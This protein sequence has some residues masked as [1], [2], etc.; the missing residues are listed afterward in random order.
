MKRLSNP[1][2]RL[3]FP[4]WAASTATCLC[5][6]SVPLAQEAVPATNTPKL[7]ET[8]KAETDYRNWFDVSVGGNFIKGDKASFQERH[9][10]PKGA[11]GGVEDFHYEQDLGKK[12]LFEIDGRGIFDNQDYS[13]RLNVQHPDYGYLRG[14]YREFRTW[15]DSSGGYLPITD[16]FFHLKDEEL[17]LDRGELWFE[18]GLT[19]PEMPV[20]T[21]RYSHQF[22]D[23]RKDSTIWGDT[24]LGLT[25]G[26]VRGVVPSFLAI[27][28]ERDIFEFDAEHTI[29]DTRFGVGLRYENSDQNDSRNILRRP[30]EAPERYLTEREIVE[31]DLFNVH[32]FQETWFTETLLFTTGYSFTTMDTDIGGSRIYGSDYDSLY[33][34][35]FVRRQQRDEGFFDLA[36][37]TKLQQHVA[38]LNLMITPFDN[39][40]IVPSLRIENQ[41]QSGIASFEETNVGAP[42]ALTST[43]EEILNTRERGFTDV[44]EGLE[45]RYTGFTNWVLYT[46]G[47]W[48]EGEGNLSERETE[49]ETGLVT[50][51]TDSTRFTQKYVVGANWYP[52]R[53]LNL[54]AQYYHKSRKND[55]DHLTDSTS[56]ALTSG[57]R[58]PAFIRDQDFTTDDVNFRVTIR[59]V[60]QLTFVSRYDFQLST[61]DSRMDNLDRVQSADIISH[62]FGESIS[63][64]P[65]N[66]LFLQGSIN[67]AIDRAETPA[68]GI[69]PGD[70]VQRSDND[71]IDASLTA[72]YAL[73]EKT[74]LQAQYFVYYSDNY[75]DNSAFSV[76]YNAS[77][78]EHGI[79]G[80]L[81]HRFTSAMQWTLKY[82][83]FTLSD[84]TYGGR[85]DYEAHMIYSSFR[86]R[87]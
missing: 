16:R 32:A 81:I 79:T 66:R 1:I 8:V 62:I 67:Y 80:T 36:G 30:G 69:L 34:P 71:Y 55:Y 18:G 54:A 35:F 78:E 24:G 59:P 63:W 72:G 31:T 64:T 75:Q 33:D 68:V 47:E 48:L 5:G 42:P 11:Y 61:V 25:G 22:R 37:G 50:R 4:T 76:P 14:G 86:Y 83:W 84:R 53:K 65:I 49:A 6:V 9:G 12:G 26:A 41:D 51:D 29:S 3:T 60:S 15:S 7:E 19:L 70:V 10:L 23:G 82:G 40:T 73:T 56:N 43:A 38:N 20:F 46:R 45:F 39:F 57:D 44:S 17:A 28:E 74:D 21:F 2:T 77:A 87:F 27:D 58:Y 13:L 85:N 52:V